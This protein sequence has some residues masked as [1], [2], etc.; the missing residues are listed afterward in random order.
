VCLHYKDTNGNELL[1]AEDINDVPPAIFNKLD[2]GH[3][4]SI[5]PKDLEDAVKK[6]EAFLS[7]V[8]EQIDS[9]TQDFQRTK[10]R[11]VALQAASAVEPKEEIERLEVELEEHQQQI[12]ELEAK[13]RKESDSLAAIHTSFKRGFVTDLFSKLASMQVNIVSFHCYFSTCIGLQM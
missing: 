12:A 7:Q 1:D 11:L 4:H 10:S 5:R 6:S 2:V 9:K 8:D 13:H 3:T